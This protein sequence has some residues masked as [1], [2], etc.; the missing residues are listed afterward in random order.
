MAN[1]SI[2]Q[3]VTVLPVS[4]LARAIDF[5]H[6]LGFTSRRYKDGDSYAFIQRDGH[7]LHLSTN[8]NLSGNRSP[9]G[10]Y[11]YLAN[12]TA[13]ALEA[14]FRSTGT[15]IAEPL[16]PREWGMN[17]FVVNDPDGN[18]LVFGEGIAQT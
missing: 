16:A 18:Q 12:G 4:D 7:A 5:Y 10:A 8:R 15:P 13:A 3:V 11:F 9:A 17:E 2:I 1:S 14:E 6:R